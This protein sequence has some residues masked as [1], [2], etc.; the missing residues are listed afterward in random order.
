MKP[1]RYSNLI[2]NHKK[3]IVMNKFY[4]FLILLITFL[5]FSVAGHAQETSGKFTGK[6]LD[7]SGQPLPGATVTAV[8]QPSGTR[9]ATASGS[10]GRYH[11]NGLRIGGPYVIT[12]SMVGMNP[13]QKGDLQATLGDPIIVDFA[14]TDN[15]R[16]LSDVVVRATGGSAKANTYGAGQNINQ[17][18]IQN[19]PSLTRSIQDLTRLVPQAS[20]D[21]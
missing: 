3:A 21:N 8:H 9:Y 5:S 12:V 10:D 13:Q 16:Q 6:V 19:M 20:K 11:L 7:A 18:T 14:L 17:G 4:T 2:F 15:S 1:I